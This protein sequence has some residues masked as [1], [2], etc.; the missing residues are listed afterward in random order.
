MDFIEF[1]SKAN[2]KHKNLYSYLYLID[3]GNVMI[4][5]KIHGNFKQNIYNHLRGFGCSECSG[6][7][8]YS[9]EKF[10]EESIKLHGNEYDYSKVYYTNK[11]KKVDIICKKHGIFQQ[12]PHTHLRGHKCAKC[13]GNANLTSENFIPLI[14]IKYDEDINKKL[15]LIN[16]NAQFFK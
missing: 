1:V 9:N 14:I 15:K 6:K 5:C 3:K 8:K 4:N 2:N 16:V 11:H 7:K 10:I 13:F 12:T